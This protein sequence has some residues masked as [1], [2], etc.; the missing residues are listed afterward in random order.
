MELA[1]K[2]V[3]RVRGRAAVVVM[4]M[5]GRYRQYKANAAES[6]RR[7][8]VQDMRDDWDEIKAASADDRAELQQRLK[9]SRENR[10]DGVNR[11]AVNI[12]A[13]GRTAVASIIWPVEDPLVNLNWT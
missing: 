2:G 11:F 7:I 8:L 3:P 13:V 6:E 4:R 9:E 10:P 12:S 5:T 1:E